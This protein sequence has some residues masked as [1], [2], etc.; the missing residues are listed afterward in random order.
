[1]EGM[2]NAWEADPA[3]PVMAQADGEMLG[4]QGGDGNTAD[5]GTAAEGEVTADLPKKK[6]RKARTRKRGGAA[7]PPT[8]ADA[9]NQGLPGSAMA[10]GDVEAGQGLQETADAFRDDPRVKFLQEQ[11]QLQLVALE[12]SLAS[13][14]AAAEGHAA[15]IKKL[16]DD[17]EESQNKL[18]NAEKAVKIADNFTGDEAARATKEERAF[19][20]YR[21]EHEETIKAAPATVTAL[22]AARKTVA[23]LTSEL[24]DA[25]DILSSMIAQRD[26]SITE[27]VNLR[28]AN[29]RL[30]SE[31]ATSKELVAT[32]AANHDAANSLLA[33]EI[34]QVHTELEDAF[35]DMAKDLTMDEKFAYARDLQQKTTRLEST[36]Q[37]EI[38]EPEA[39]EPE[40]LSFSKITSVETV[41]VAAVAATA[42]KKPL[43]FSAISSV[44][45]PPVVLPA[46]AAPA[47]A[48]K[49]PMSFSGITSVETA[50]VAAPV[51]AAATTKKPMTFSGITSVNTAPVAAAPAAVK[52]PL[53]EVIEVTKI[54]NVPYDRFVDRAVFP[55]W[56]LLLLLLG[57]L[58]CLGG[59]AAL[60]REQQIWVTANDTAYQRLM[61]TNQETWLEWI[62][63]GVK[64]LVLPPI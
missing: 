44:N 15:T 7:A 35:S 3:W 16:T 45:T 34:A 63:L 23:D 46:A 36:L 30:E 61:G 51:A 57:L 10:T 6:I 4:A 24:K 52:K 32:N 28:A 39:A 8:E 48:A 25:D 14:D 60:W 43:K 17:L 56:M 55:W 54:V 19:Q 37:D 5:E 41:P 38:E 2:E 62:V 42:A 12:E 13:R 21:D 31:L 27:C 9:G 49:K 29:E 1:M 20:K 40:V 58:A 11:H 53:A 33:D 22:A 18:R 64:D 26:E 47:A 59:F 50:P